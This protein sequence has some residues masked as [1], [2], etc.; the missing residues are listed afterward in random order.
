MLLYWLAWILTRLRYADAGRPRS[1]AKA[2]VIRDAVARDPTVANIMAEIIT[3]TCILFGVNAP[4]THISCDFLINV[5]YHT[6]RA[7]IGSY[8]LSKNLNVWILCRGIQRCLDVSCRE[9]DRDKHAEPESPVQGDRAEH[10][11]RDYYRRI[12]NFLSFE[13]PI[14]S[15]LG[16]LLLKKD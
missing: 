14:I 9:Q 11:T 6:G 3:A 13:A 8:S 1:R 4:T 5:T 10:A 12:L 2:H 16:R 7:P 15:T